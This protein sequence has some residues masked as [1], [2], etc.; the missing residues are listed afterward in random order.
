MLL[1]SAD[2]SVCVCVSVPVHVY[3]EVCVKQ[4]GRV[5]LTVV[6]FGKDQMNEVKGTLE[7]TSRY[8]TLMCMCVCGSVCVH[9]KEQIRLRLRLRN[10][11]LNKKEPEGCLKFLTVT[12][13]PMHYGFCPNCG[14]KL[15]T[16]SASANRKS[17]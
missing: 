12:S 3:R 17:T 9:T 6:Y 10:S 14:F 13:F 8:G 5:H 7:N 16:C 1:E 2:P 15:F 4:D 11:Q